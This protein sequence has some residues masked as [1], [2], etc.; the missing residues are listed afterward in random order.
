MPSYDVF[1][2]AD[3][4]ELR[5]C[6]ICSS[7]ITIGTPFYSQIM[8]AGNHELSRVELM[9]GLIRMCPFHLPFFCLQNADVFGH[10]FLVFPI[11]KDY[12]WSY[13]VVCLSKLR[14]GDA[15]DDPWKGVPRPSDPPPPPFPWLPWIQ[16]V[17]EQ[18][19]FWWFLLHEL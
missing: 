3:L 15:Q 14:I 13:A 12:H 19:F 10:K 4:Y 18:S 11:Y 5:I 17:I 2:G 1:H 6:L 8:G 9:Q 7:K 16:C